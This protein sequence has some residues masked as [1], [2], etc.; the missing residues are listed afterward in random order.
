MKTI[1]LACP[2]T[3]KDPK[4][5]QQRFEIVNQKAAELM[6][7]GFVVYSPIT[8]SHLLEGLPQTWEFWQTQCLPLVKWADEFVVLMLD[9]WQESVGVNAETAYAKEINKPIRYIHF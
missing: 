5:R 1:Y 8:H 4:I 7:K 6:R 2:Y 3:H 9:G